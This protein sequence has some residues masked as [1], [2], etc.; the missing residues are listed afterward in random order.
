MSAEKIEAL[1]VVQLAVKKIMRNFIMT[2][3]V[4]IDL[5][6]MIFQDLKVVIQII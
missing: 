4:V 2:E 6:M 1:H 3:V 5:M